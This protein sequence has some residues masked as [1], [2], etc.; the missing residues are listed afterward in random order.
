[1]KAKCT[2]M[3]ATRRSH[4]LAIALTATLALTIGLALTEWRVDCAAAEAGAVNVKTT[5]LSI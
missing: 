2:T 5:K 3:K 4:L 1:M